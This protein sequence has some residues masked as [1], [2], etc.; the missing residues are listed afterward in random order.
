MQEG[1]PVTSFP[2]CGGCHAVGFESAVEFPRA[3]D[4]VGDCEDPEGGEAEIECR[5]GELQIRAVHFGGVDFSAVRVP[6]RG[7]G[8]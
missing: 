1:K 2:C 6:G 4:G 7:V 5:V 8:G 3:F